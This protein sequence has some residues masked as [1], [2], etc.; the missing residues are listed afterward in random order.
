MDRQKALKKLKIE[1]PE[2]YANN[3]DEGVFKFFPE[4]YG[5]YFEMV[6][7]VTM[8]DVL[9]DFVDYLGLTYLAERAQ[10]KTAAYASSPLARRIQSAFL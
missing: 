4:R 8:L 1:F 10:E 3:P 7:P 2:K 5:D 9:K 6:Y